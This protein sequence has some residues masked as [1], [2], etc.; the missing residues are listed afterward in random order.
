MRKILS[1][2]TVGIFTCALTFGQAKTVTGRVTDSQGNP[3]PYATVTVRGGGQ[4]TSADQNGQFSLSVKKGDVLVVS[5][6]ELKTKTITVGDSDAITIQVEASDAVLEE[7]VVTAGGFKAKKKEI[8]TATTVVKA[9]ELVAGKAV[10]I[11]GGLQGKVAG[12]QINATG[13]G[14]NP[15]FRLVLRG[16]RS[17]TGNN[18]ALVVLDNVIVPNEIL[19]N[20]NPEDVE[21]VTVLNGGGAAAL[22]GSQASNGAILITTKKGRKG[23][24]AVTVSNTTTLQQTAFF[25]K[26]QT[27]YGG[28]GFG[29][30]ADEFGNPNFSYLENQ[31]YGPQYDGTK[32]PL[33]SPLEDGTQDS[34]IYAYNPGHK[35][36]WETG[37]QNQTDFSVSSGDEVSTFYVSGQYASVTGTTPGDKFN[38]TVLRVNGTRKIGSKILVSY[39]TSYTQNRYDITSQTGSMYGN[40]LNMPSWVDITRYK[41]W[42]TDKF[43]NPN[44][45]YNPWYQNPYFT[46]DNYRSKSRNDYLVGNI[47]L[48]FTPIKGLDLVARQGLATRNYSSQNTV[49]EFLYTEYAKHTEASSKSDIPGSVS[50]GS[51]YTTNLLT[52]LYAEY[53]KEVG[54]FEYNLIGGTQ[55]NQNESKNMGISANGLVVPDLYNV[56][57]GVGTPG[58]SAAMYKARQV[59]AYGKAKIGYKKFLYVNG[60]YRNDWVSTLAPENRS[61]SYW[62]VEGSFLPSV[63]IDAIQNSNVIS[64]LKLRGGY[65]KVGQV[66]LLGNF[67]AYKLR[68]TFSSGAFGFPYGSLPGYTVDNLLVANTLKPEF[69]K[70]YEFGFDLGMFNDRVSAAFTYFNTKTDNQTVTTRVSNATGFNDL[71][72]NTGQTQSKGIEVSLNTLPVRT[73]DWEVT[74][75]GNYSYLD[76]NVNSISADLRNLALATYGNGAGSYGVEGRAFPVIMGYDYKRDPQGRVIINQADGLP[77]KSDTISILGNAVAKHKLGLN[78]SVSW[79]NFSFSMLWEYRGGYQAYHAM[80]GEMDWSGTG[81]RTAIYNRERFV[82]PNSVYWDGNKYVENTNITVKN[83]GGNNGFWSDGINRDVQSNYVT[84]GDF[85]KLREMSIAYDVPVAK[86]FGNNN[87]VKGMRVSVQGRNLLLFMAKDNYYTDP[88]YSDA[89]NDSNGIGLTGIGQTPPAR[90]Y[91]GTLTFRF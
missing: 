29:Y 65:S 56:S 89:G 90:Y 44:G 26:F 66:N 46:A 7:V 32:R 36:F 85:W 12:L 60:S 43:A 59:G 73:K 52:D 8:G 81:Y 9:E 72:T 37:V 67:G 25:P 19:G 4:G 55:F 69:T 51:G 48:K 11:A 24:T 63:V 82:F 27:K 53:S 86:L 83:G 57:N 64:N 47:E 50:E 16:Q 15:N 31:S 61:F 38:R 34:A 74:I 84:S 1:L 75:G 42:R 5:G 76:N 41:N 78:G 58:V 3:V 21:N 18:Q 87:I 35:K 17:L 79:K 71:L 54:D 70:G 2:L 6:T 28:G 45:F 88:E 33:G 20:L 91:G 77:T 23:I 10:N 30:S 22:Y 39:T 80:G 40:M 14:V 13:G 49:A 68:P 62:A